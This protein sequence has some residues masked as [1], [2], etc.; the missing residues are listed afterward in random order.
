LDVAFWTTAEIRPKCQ[1]HSSNNEAFL[2]L[3][4]EVFNP[5]NLI[6]VDIFPEEL[7]N[8]SSN[9]IQVQA[10]IKSFCEQMNEFFQKN[11][12]FDLDYS[13]KSAWF[14]T[15][16]GKLAKNKSVIQVI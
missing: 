6:K 11:S 16:N 3:K 9:S 5:S 15:L 10:D 1:N 2:N 13:S 7:G 4:K 12:Q 14:K 8:N